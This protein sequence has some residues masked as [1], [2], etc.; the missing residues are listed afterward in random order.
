MVE[1]ESPLHDI[2]SALAEAN[3]MPPEEAAEMRKAAMEAIA[4]NVR[5]MLCMTRGSVFTTQRD[6]DEPGRDHHQRH[7]RNVDAEQIGLCEPYTDA[8]A[9]K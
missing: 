1:A 7:R 5:L 8:P 3:D 9:S 2:D 4:G 6:R